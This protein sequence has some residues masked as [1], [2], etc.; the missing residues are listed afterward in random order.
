MLWWNTPHNI[1]WNKLDYY[2]KLEINEKRQENIRTKIIF[3][4]SSW[5]NH[6]SFKP[7]FRA[8]HQEMAEISCYN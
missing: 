6:M 2:M 5:E 3:D 1:K 4:E 8:N 7:I